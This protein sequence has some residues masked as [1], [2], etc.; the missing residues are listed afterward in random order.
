MHVFPYSPR[1]GAVSAKWK[2]TDPVVK[3]ARAEELG[4]V[5]LQLKQTFAESM[6]GRAEPVLVE[7]IV[8]GKAVGYTPN[9]LRVYFDGDEND[10]GK[11]VDVIVGAPYLD[12]ANGTAVYAKK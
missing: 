8:D 12:G 10:V 5:K 4:K 9:Y 11:I 2:D 1:Q 3:R 6:Y 7:E